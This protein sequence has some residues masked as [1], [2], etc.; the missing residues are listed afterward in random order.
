MES[1]DRS[2]APRLPPLTPYPGLSGG[3][4]IVRG[5]RITDAPASPQPATD[6]SSSEPTTAAT[7]AAPEAAPA[8][9][10]AEAPASS[11]SASAAQQQQQHQSAAIAPNATF[12][13]DEVLVSDLLAALAR[14]HQGL[15]AEL[16]ALSDVVSTEAMMG[17]CNLAEAAKTLEDTFRRI[18]LL[19]AKVA[20]LNAY[21][22]QP[23]AAAVK[24]IHAP[25]DL[26][27]KA[28]SVLKSFSILK[29]AASKI[30]GGS[31]EEEAEAMW[32]R[33]PPFVLI[34][35]PVGVSSTVPAGVHPSA[36]SSASSSAA[37]AAQQAAALFADDDEKPTAPFGTPFGGTA[38]AF[39]SAAPTVWTSQA[40]FTLGANLSLLQPLSAAAA[41]SGAASSPPQQDADA[42]S[43]PT[44]RNS[45]SSNFFKA[46][47]TAEG[48]SANPSAAAAPPAPVIKTRP[49]EFRDEVVANSIF[50]FEQST[51]N[52]HQ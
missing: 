16:T 51:V 20:Y 42:L 29:S 38:A 25:R 36:S 27:G 48:A 28:L 4:A 22:A 18:D 32:S 23:L 11:S 46:D 24:N 3:E 1:S 40:P 26:K 17:V 44:K 31:K 45:G 13:V 39:A 7:A 5:L 12:A 41:A 2:S 33:I 50:Y 15:V 37:A 8:E 6:S 34:G 14:Q 9:S 21:V 52:R 47:Y 30:G 19:H 35:G 10:S 43:P 49:Q